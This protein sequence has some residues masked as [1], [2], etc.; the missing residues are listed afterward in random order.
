MNAGAVIAAGGQ[1]I[2]MGTH[3]PKQ[4]LKLGG[5]TIL[6]RALEPFI[7]CTKI[8]QIVIVT[9][10]SIIDTIETIIRK[11]QSCE[12]PITVVRGGYVRQESV[13]NGIMALDEDTGI[14]VIHD[15]VRPFITE[16][17]IT[18]CLHAAAKHGSVS[19]MRPITETVKIVEDSVVVRTPDRSILW[20]TQT[21]QAFRKELIVDAH[22]RA[23]DDG[24]IGT[25]DCMLVERLGHTVHVIEGSDM[26]IKITTPTDMK[27]AEAIFNMF[28][29]RRLTDAANRPRV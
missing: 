7:N 4:L 5:I 14:V 16:K 29:D 15:A 27:I 23:R 18:E 2:R 11:K 10:D 3:L 12:K 20:I 9:A 1:G 21:P 17:L 26:N 8:N 6:E 25:D 22:I 19:V 28:E 24:I 13:F